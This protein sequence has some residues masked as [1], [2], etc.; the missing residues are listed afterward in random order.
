M[1]LCVDFDR[2]NISQQVVL[3]FE[4]RGPTAAYALASHPAAS[5]VHMRCL[6]HAISGSL[7]SGTSLIRAD[8]VFG[9]T[10]ACLPHYF[11]IP[12]NTFFRG[13]YTR[14]SYLLVSTVMF[15]YSQISY[16]FFSTREG[17][18]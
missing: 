11:I 3:S 5:R 4:Y 7:P 17:V 14:L 18:V 10:T 9:C 16:L 8:Y 2:W 13:I 1:Y 15:F 12:Q 6:R